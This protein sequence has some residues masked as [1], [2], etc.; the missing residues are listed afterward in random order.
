MQALPYW[1]DTINVAS[2]L[3]GAAPP[4]GITVSQA[5]FDATKDS[6][7]YQPSRLVALKGIGEV[8]VYDVELG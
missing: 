3:E 8:P 6:C 7:R 5:T 4:N 1:G 2:R